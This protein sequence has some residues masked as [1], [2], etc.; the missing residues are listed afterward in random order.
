MSKRIAVIGSLNVDNVTYT[1]NPPTPGKTVFGESF[2]SNLGGKGAN[3][4]LAIQFLGGDSI[5]FGCKGKDHLRQYPGGH[6]QSVYHFRPGFRQA[7][8]G[9]RQD[10]QSRRGN[11]ADL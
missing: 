1:N 11:P 4:A 3:Q 7:D 9:I 2:V 6:Y 10:P 8:P 5:Y